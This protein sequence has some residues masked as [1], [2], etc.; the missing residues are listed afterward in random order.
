M[1]VDDKNNK[2]T[3]TA[4]S[5]VVSQELSTSPRA[6]DAIQQDSLAMTASVRIEPIC[7][8]CRPTTFRNAHKHDTTQ[9]I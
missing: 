8:H 2:Q 7:A 3:A 1:N 6:D 9:N 5:S 4:T